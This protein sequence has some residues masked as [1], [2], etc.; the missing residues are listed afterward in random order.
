MV[1]RTDIV[2]AADAARKMGLSLKLPRGS[3]VDIAIPVDITRRAR[4]L[5]VRLEPVAAVGRC[6][7]RVHLPGGA[8]ILEPRGPDPAVVI[9]ELDE[10]LAELS[11]T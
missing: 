5:G 3:I 8:G 7:V 6:A 4:A 11:A 9:S 10:I 1:T 2:L